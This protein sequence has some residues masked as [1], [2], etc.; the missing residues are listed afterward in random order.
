MDPMILGCLG[1][2]AAI[3]FAVV[4]VRRN[5]RTPGDSRG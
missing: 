3:A 4:I 1:A 2:V 5:R